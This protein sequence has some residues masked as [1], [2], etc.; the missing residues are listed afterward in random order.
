MY[1]H[2]MMT[3]TSSME[4]RLGRTPQRDVGVLEEQE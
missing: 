1:A 4:D 3:A 2:E